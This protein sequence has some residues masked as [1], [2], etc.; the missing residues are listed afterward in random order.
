M[1]KNLYSFI[2]KYS[3][4]QQVI[5]T[6][7][8][9]VSFVPYYYYLSIPKSIVNQ[10]IE[11][12][13][14]AFPV[15]LFGLGLWQMDR[16]TYLFWLCG[17]FLFLVL[18]QQGF[19]Y[20]INY[21]QG[22]A[23]ERMLRRL[24]YELYAHIL[25][26]PLPTFRRTSQGEIIPM[27]IAEVEPVGGFIG[28]SFALPIFQGGMLLVIFGFLLLQNPLMAL[29]AVALYPI[30][31]YFVPRMQAKVRALGRERIKNQRRLSDR[32]GES[33]SGVTELH[34]HDVSNRMLA[35]FTNRLSISYWIRVEIYQRKFMV[36]FLN[37]F[38]QQLGPFFF[39]AIGGYLTIRGQ[40][41][42]GTVVA[43]VNAHKEMASPWKELLNHYQQREDVKQKYEQV[44]S[45]FVIDGMRDPTDQNSEP[46]QPV[47]LTGPISVSGLVMHDD[48]DQ[49]ILENL[50]LS[51]PWPAR[52]A[53]VGDNG[54]DELLQLLARLHDPT[55]GRITINERNL[56]ELPETVTG[57]RLAYVGSASYIFN[58]TLGDNLFM[59]LRH[60]PMT[61]REMEESLQTRYEREIVEAQ[62]SGNSPYDTDADWT[63]YAAA[64][65]T[66]PDDLVTVAILS[67]KAAGFD[68]DVYQIGMRG[69]LDPR[70]K[71]D[72]AERVLA[73]RRAF[74][75]KL[76]SGALA[77]LVE[78]WNPALYNSNATVAE[79][80]MF[81]TARNGVYQEDNLA[82][83]PHMLRVLDEVGLRR[84]FLEI[85]YEVADTMVEL[86]A[87]LPP[88]HE[89]FQQFSFISS[90]DLP[91]Y[92]DL[93]MRAKPETLEQLPEADRVRLMSLPFKLVLARHRLG[94]FN[95]A[96]REA[97]LKARKIFAETLPEDRKG[98]IAFFDPE[99]FT[100]SSSIVDN[101]LFGRVAYGQAQAQEKIGRVMADVVE[102]LQLREPIIAVGLQ[103]EVGIAGARLNAAQRQKLAIARALVK[104]PDWVM[105]SEATAALDPRSHA[106]AIKAISELRKDAG[107]IWSLQRASDCESFD[108]VVVVENGRVTHTGPYAELCEKSARFKQMLAPA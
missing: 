45:Q 5:I 64:G 102:Q 17:V 95:D 22:V 84:R 91:D 43:A 42:V 21:F 4:K 62:A 23:G 51:L 7:L 87:D 28:E 105:L 10:G 9:I 47:S 35:E 68:E 82:R 34:T 16:T 3:L 103:F 44:V 63:D 107:L 97:I 69:S 73:A 79:N 88:E 31:F 85:G 71:P 104:R 36:K 61:K 70:A 67:L 52:V 57:R 33:I 101:I 100:V 66:G 74:R 108:I 81:G 13:D 75:E 40:M 6:L 83:D 55:R 30:Q 77:D 54:R 8:S 59:G 12:K 49:P 96:E 92:K 76:T 72:V 93:L 26:F 32:I 15:D 18:I 41:D 27:V 11:G 94:H 78:S 56:S 48:Q 106:A 20:A 25:R 2:L 46:E 24:R 58:T 65:A 50:S 80:L 60:R 99:H 98:T 39:Y 37:N 29:A 86:F 89:F 90:D 1:E 19:K 14:I 53:V 38:I